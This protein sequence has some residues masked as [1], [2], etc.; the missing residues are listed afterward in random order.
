[1]RSIKLSASKV[2][3][4]IGLNKYEPI[5]KAVADLL[6]PSFSSNIEKQL[7]Y[8]KKE[9]IKEIAT[10]LGLDKETKK[11]IVIKKVEEK[12]KEASK[13]TISEKESKENTKKIIKQLGLKGETKKAVESDVSMK[14]GQNLEKKDI[15]KIQEQKKT[16]IS[17]RN[18]SFYT[19]SLEL[20]EYDN[21]S[22][23]CTIIGKID[24][25]EEET[26]RLVES[27][28]RRS[29]LFKYVPIYEKVQCEIYMRMINVDECLHCEHYN[30]ETNEVIIKK[31]DSLW[32]TITNNL[33][34]KF[35]PIYC[36]FKNNCENN[37]EPS[38][39]C[40]ID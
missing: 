15:N 4:Y 7:T 24:G 3:S 34:T 29:R 39:S 8:V 31:D 9:E 13:N 18:D 14:R 19:L 35:L 1:M 28:H 30:E 25:F 20:G 6:G 2:A 32:D 16:V 11:E 22:Y 5:E 36:K 21:I 37:D 12:L 17:K 10:K 40:E 33:K 27:K 26:S 23:K 38:K